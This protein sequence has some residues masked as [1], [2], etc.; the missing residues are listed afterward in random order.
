MLIGVVRASCPDCGDIEVHCDDVTVR[1]CV[2]TRH[3]SYRF[4]CP[5]CAMTSVKD[6]GMGAVTLLL[7]AGVPVE[8]WNLPLEFAERPAQGEA[9]NHDDLIDIHQALEL[10][11]TAHR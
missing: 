4:R 2:E 3:H 9:I 1:R 8:H 11:P 5:I 10:L 7:R 6:A